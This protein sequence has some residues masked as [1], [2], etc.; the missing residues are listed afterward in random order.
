MNL[1]KLNFKFLNLFTLL[2]EQNANKLEVSYCED[3]DTFG[4]HLNAK[5]YEKW[6][7]VLG[8]L[9]FQTLNEI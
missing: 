8:P 7:E 9:I 5:G 4:L 1:E 6:F 2:K 3:P